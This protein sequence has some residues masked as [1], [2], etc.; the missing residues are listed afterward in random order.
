MFEK[1][2]G[3][4]FIRPGTSH[5]GR[6]MV[7]VFG[8]VSMSDDIEGE[9]LYLGAFQRV[10]G[11]LRFGLESTFS[12]RPEFYGRLTDEED[13]SGLAQSSIWR[14]GHEARGS[15]LV[16]V[17]RAGLKPVHGY[18]RLYL[19]VS[20]VSDDGG[21]FEGLSEQLVDLDA[22]R[23]V[24]SATPAKSAGS[25]PQ[26]VLRQPFFLMPEGDR[27]AVVYTVGPKTRRAMIDVSEICTKPSA[28]RSADEIA[29]IEEIRRDP[30]LRFH[31]HLYEKPDN[32]DF[33]AYARS[34]RAMPRINDRLVTAQ[35]LADRDAFS[36]Q[37]I[38]S[39]MAAAA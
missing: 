4:L 18:Q 39:T 19:V 8:L 37:V 12:Q 1:P 15:C 23:Q 5:D 16:F 26:Q 7:G 31:L 6:R 32:A 24:G 10:G 21:I 27:R 20:V 33:Q 17:R 14:G 11:Q 30:E 13:L 29:R 34:M 35:E 28:D 38:R 22:G 3:T 36:A 9:R 2:T 25:Q